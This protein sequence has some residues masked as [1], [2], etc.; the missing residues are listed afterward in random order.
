M[1]DRVKDAC[2]SMDR[3]GMN[4]IGSRLMS[5]PVARSRGHYEHLEQRECLFC[6][7]HVSRKTVQVSRSLAAQTS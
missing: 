6:D 5:P 3:E 4:R 7:S 2:H 1:M